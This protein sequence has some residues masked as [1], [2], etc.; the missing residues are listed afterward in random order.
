M[1]G[2]ANYAIDLDRGIITS[3]LLGLRMLPED[4]AELARMVRKRD[5]SVK[6]RE[7]R[8]VDGQFAITFSQYAE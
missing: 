2:K 3:V 7:A 8:K 5:P 1:T 6:I 4:K